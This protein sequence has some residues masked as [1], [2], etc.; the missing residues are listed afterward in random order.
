ME[1]AVKDASLLS[2]INNT[3][4]VYRLCETYVDGKHVSPMDDNGYTYRLFNK[5][6]YIFPKVQSKFDQTLGPGAYHYYRN[7]SFAKNCFIYKKT[8]KN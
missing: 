6:T 3:C 1:N 8:F 5:A 4:S 7:K 2:P